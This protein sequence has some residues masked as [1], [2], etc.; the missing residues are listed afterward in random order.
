MLLEEW[1]GGVIIS[2]HIALRLKLRAQWYRANMVICLQSCVRLIKACVWWDGS[3]LPVGQQRTPDAF[4]KRFPSFSYFFTLIFSILCNRRM[5]RA[6]RH[7]H[8]NWQLSAGGVGVKG[9]S[10]GNPSAANKSRQAGSPDLLLML[11]LT[12]Q[13]ARPVSRP[14]WPSG[15]LRSI[16]TPR[17][18]IASVSAPL[19]SL[20][21]AFE[22]M[23]TRAIVS[24]E[25]HGRKENIMA[26]V[27]N[28]HPVVNV[29]IRAVNH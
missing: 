6:R 13:S 27:D 25:F 20:V 12:W 5:H 26:H 22:E 8:N 3:G 10:A 9:G 14:A 29:I 7:I 23:F 4:W 24:Y 1:L 11:L 2:A 19:V 15:R 16:T 28:Y 17:I 18:M 21:P